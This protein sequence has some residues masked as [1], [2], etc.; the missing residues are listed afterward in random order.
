MA[1]DFNNLP[2][3]LRLKI[4]S[5]GLSRE[6]FAKRAGLSRPSIYFYLSGRRRPTTQTMTEICRVLG[7]PLE[8]GL[9]QYV[10]KPTGRHTVVKK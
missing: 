4:G 6:R 8:E 7:V 2:E 3:W 10:N 9:R 1:T 5:T